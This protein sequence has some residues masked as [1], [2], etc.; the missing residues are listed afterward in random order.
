[1]SDRELPPVVEALLEWRKRNGL[2][3]EAAVRVMATYGYPVTVASLAQWEKG[4]RKPSVL[5]A[6]AIMGFL[7]KYPVVPPS[8]PPYPLG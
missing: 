2:S 7:Q 1:M 6:I 5:A 8:A 3:Q 4:N